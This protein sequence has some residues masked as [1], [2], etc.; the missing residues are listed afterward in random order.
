MFY[1][2]PLVKIMKTISWLEKLQKCVLYQYDPE[3]QP[4]EEEEEASRKREEQKAGDED[5]DDE[6]SFAPDWP[7]PCSV[8][9][10]ET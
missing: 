8:E 5:E 7:V 10:N 1:Q 6:P 4:E 9:V 2:G 3:N